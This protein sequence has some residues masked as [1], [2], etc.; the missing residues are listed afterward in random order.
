MLQIQGIRKI[1]IKSLMQYNHKT[2]RRAECEIKY[3]IASILPFAFLLKMYDSSGYSTFL[4]TFGVVSLLCFSHS[5]EWVLETYYGLICISLMTN[6]FKTFSC[7]II[8]CLSGQTCL[9]CILQMIHKHI[10][11][12][13]KKIIIMKNR[14]KKNPVF[15]YLLPHL[16]R[17]VNIQ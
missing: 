5:N 1:Q 17:E 3:D 15:V 7:E 8:T 16:C 14:K 13:E 12:T 10:S 4:T 9:Y 6:K 11:S 2:I